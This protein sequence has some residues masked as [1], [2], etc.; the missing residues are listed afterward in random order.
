MPNFMLTAIFAIVARLDLFEL[1]E[2]AYGAAVKRIPQP[3]LDRINELVRN[4]DD[5]DLPGE[6]KFREV[7]SAL[8]TPNSAIRALLQGIPQRILLIAIQGAYERMRAE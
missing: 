2:V 3:V 7:V 1:A 8:K 5:L 4:V 6:E